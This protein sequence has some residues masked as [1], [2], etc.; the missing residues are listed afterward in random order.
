MDETV[1]KVNGYRSYV[2]SAIDMESGEILAVHASRGR[3]ILNALAFIR[4]VLKCLVA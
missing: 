3:S 4:R 1:V 2:W